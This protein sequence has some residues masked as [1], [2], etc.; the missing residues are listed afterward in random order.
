MTNTG[1][2]DN[3]HILLWLVKDTCWMLEWRIFGTL[4][5]VPTIGVAVYL[6][7]KSTAEDIFW[8]NLAICFWITAN[9]YWMVC[10]FVELEMYKDYAG[11]PFGLGLI[12]VAVFYVR[13]KLARVGED[14]AD[15]GTVGL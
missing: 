14:P 1:R 5:I 4:M 11:I 6:A 10:E 9:A 12:S 3:I 7:A 13:T 15:R 2:F 8:I